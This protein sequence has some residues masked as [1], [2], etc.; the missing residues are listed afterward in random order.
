MSETS[1]TVV[2]STV[3]VHTLFNVGDVLI[4]VIGQLPYEEDDVNRGATTL[5]PPP[6]PPPTVSVEFGYF[7]RQIASK[8]I[9]FITDRVVY[10]LN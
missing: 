5:R 9:T 3:H 6:R 4:T 10:R 2:Y 7:D 8:F 1:L